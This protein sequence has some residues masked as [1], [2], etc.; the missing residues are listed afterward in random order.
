[1]H[2]H[3]IL[4]GYLSRK[5]VY[6]YDDTPGWYELRQ[7][8]FRT[9]PNDIINQTSLTNTPLVL[10][11]YKIR[12]VVL[13]PQYLSADELITATDVLKATF[14]N[15]QPYYKDSEL[16]VYRATDNVPA[17]ITASQLVLD[18][19]Q[20][21]NVLD[22]NQRTINSASQLQIFNPSHTALTVKLTTQVQAK[23]RSHQLTVKWA[24]DGKESTVDTTTVST[25]ATP[26]S[27]ELSLQPGLNTLTFQPDSTG[28]NI[29]T[30]GAIEV[31]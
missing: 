14:G 2:N 27:F 11:Y 25:Q 18:L 24:N 16:T 31:R 4:G 12:Y 20:G 3:P 17:N 23:T 19:G 5:E 8:N 7:L 10:A 29:L 21:W 30:F 1:M 9:Q 26:V 22:N 13:H 15:A 6:P 28:N